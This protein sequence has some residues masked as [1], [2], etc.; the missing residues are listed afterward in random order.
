MDHRAYVGGKWN[1]IGEL[2]F[3]FIKKNGLLPNHCFLDIGCGSLRGGVHFIHYLHKGNYLGLEANERVLSAGINK[4]LGI[5]IQDLKSP[6]FVVSSKFNFFKFN[7]TP[8]FSLA[9]SLFTH[10]NTDEIMVC[11][12]NLYFFVNKGHLF[13]ASFQIGDSSKNP[14]PVV[15]KVWQYHHDKV[16]KYSVEEISDL[17]SGLGWK[18]TYIGEWSHPYGHIIMKFEK[19]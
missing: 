6:Q 7:K 4:E 13:F 3:Q 8:D 5:K 16:W 9:Q 19:P 14:D 17:A 1:V 15:D 2:Q 10:L 11:L 12:R 18:P